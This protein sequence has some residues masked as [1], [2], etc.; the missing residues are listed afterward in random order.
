MVVIIIVKLAKPKAPY[1][2]LK[3]TGESLNV[4]TTGKVLV[5]PSGNAAV[6][7]SF[8]EYVLN[9]NRLT[10]A[11]SPFGG[12]KGSGS[13][14]YMP[15]TLN[16]ISGDGVYLQDTSGTNSTKTLTAGKLKELS[17]LTVDT[18]AH[19]ITEEFQVVNTSESNNPTVIDACDSATGWSVLLGSGAPTVSTSEKIEGTGSITATGGATD[20]NGKLIFEKSVTLD[21]SQKQFVTL[22]ATTSEN[23]I[24]VVLQGSPI[25]PYD[26]VKVVIGNADVANAT[27]VDAVVR[28]I[29]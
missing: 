11:E 28:V 3:V 21:L 13:P 17:L 29:M 23:D 22:N 14:D 12:L 15:G 4:E 24:V 18:A 20:Q 10:I 26:A 6:L 19:S 25:V 27:T 2:K 9:S 1:E 8:N 7:P 5:L 16:I